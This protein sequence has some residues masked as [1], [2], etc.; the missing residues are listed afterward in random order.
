ME[1]AINQAPV[2]VIDNTALMLWEMKF[3]FD[4][5]K[6]YG[7]I[8]VVIEPRTPWKRDVAVLAHKSSHN[9]P[10]DILLAKVYIYNF[11]IKMLINHFF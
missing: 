11:M 3:Y 9:I 4:L 8:T 7:Y 1:A 2:I 5:A 10:Q 6:A